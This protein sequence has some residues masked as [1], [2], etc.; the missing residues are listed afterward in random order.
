MKS[1]MVDYS[2][3]DSPYRQEEKLVGWEKS[4][5]QQGEVGSPDLVNTLRSLRINIINCKFDNKQMI[6]D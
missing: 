2:S 1:R 3:Y 6:E 4:V 5:E